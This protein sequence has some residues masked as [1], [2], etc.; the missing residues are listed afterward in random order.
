MHSNSHSLLMLADIRHHELQDE[1]ARLYLV[2]TASRDAPT[3]HTAFATAC[4]RLGATLLRAR[5]H[6]KVIR[7]TLAAPRRG[8]LPH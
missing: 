8:A 4:R 5:P 6:L 7:W 3:V 1:I 2:R